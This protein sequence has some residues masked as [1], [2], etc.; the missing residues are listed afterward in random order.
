MGSI[1]LLFVRVR[2]GDQVV[3]AKAAKVVV[4][5]LVIELR[6]FRTNDCYGD[7]VVDMSDMRQ[8]SAICY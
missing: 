5:C 8:S 3:E 7:S 2:I 4:I 1:E 6:L